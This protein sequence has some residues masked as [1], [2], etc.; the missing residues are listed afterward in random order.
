MDPKFRNSGWLLFLRKE[1]QGIRCAEKK[2]GQFD[3]ICNILFLIKVLG[4]K[5]PVLRFDKA[6]W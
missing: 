6:G 1:E 2:S 5:W 4:P 3:T